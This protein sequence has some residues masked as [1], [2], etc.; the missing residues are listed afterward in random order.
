MAKLGKLFLVVI[1]AAAILLVI[2]S[3]AGRNLA[4]QSAELERVAGTDNVYR[5]SNKLVNVYLIDLGD[6][7]VLIDA[8]IDTSGEVLHSL[9][10][11]AGKHKRDVA[12]VLVT[13]G[14]GDHFTG[15]AFF[16]T[17]PTTYIGAED[18]PMMAGTIRKNDV[19][20][21]L[22]TNV[23][24]VRFFEPTHL[25]TGRAQIALPD[26]DHIVAIPAAGHTPGSY[27][28]FY[29]NVLFVGDAFDYAGGKLTYPPAVVTEDMPTAIRTIS[30]LARSLQGL[31][32][33]VICT[34]HGGCTPPAETRQLLADL[35]ADS[36]RDSRG[37]VE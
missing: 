35:V 3:I 26:G 5:V 34:G 30:T 13:H 25:I 24:D 2:A 36:A 9:L 32:V 19:P 4:T 27:L 8:G 17:P 1:G 22:L 10:E 18:A 7:A 11:L 14:H 21:L 6:E 33:A 15:L 12:A 16:A 28:Y 31:D 29:N 20:G 37:P 23:F